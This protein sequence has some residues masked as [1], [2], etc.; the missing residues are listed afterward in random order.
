MTIFIAYFK[1]DI[2]KAIPIYACSFLQSITYRKGY[3]RFR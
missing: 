1:Y 2:R 3:P